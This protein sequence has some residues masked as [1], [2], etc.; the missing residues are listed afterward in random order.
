MRF[1]VYTPFRF[2]ASVA[3]LRRGEE[4]ETKRPGQ[5][6]NGRGDP[7]CSTAK[8]VE[9]P[10]LPALPVA[11]AQVS[12]KKPPGAASNLSRRTRGERGMR[13]ERDR[14]TTIALRRQE[15]HAL[16]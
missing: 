9:E 13:G 6:E 2:I 5:A 12:E 10:V 16:G 14:L 11:T 8:L 15:W 3:A 7:G 4:A 1:L